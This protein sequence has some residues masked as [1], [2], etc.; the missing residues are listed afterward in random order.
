MNNYLIPANSKKS[1][2]IFGMFRGVDLIILLIGAS[3]SL[4][5]MFAISGDNIGIVF[6]K[7]LPLAL[8]LLL[9]VPIPQYHNVLVFLQDKDGNE[10]VKEDLQSL[11]SLNS[12][13]KSIN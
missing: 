11:I 8:S 12:K 1:Q 2:L 9:I 3:V 6:I 13:C 4:V 7:L 10:L 5:L